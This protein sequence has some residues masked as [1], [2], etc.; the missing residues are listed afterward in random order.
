MNDLTVKTKTVVVASP[1]S[2]QARKITTQAETWGEL[3]EELGGMYNDNLEAVVRPGNQSLGRDDAKLPDEDFSV[4]LIPRKNK[5]GID[6]VFTSDDAT[7]LS[8][9]IYREAMNCI[10]DGSTLDELKENVEIHMD[11]FFDALAGRK[12]AQ[13]EQSKVQTD[14]VLTEALAEAKKMI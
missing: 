5:A 2:N 1:A 6:R 14:P 8:V 3:K 4:Y 7:N 12:V 10:A 11:S 9:E 13:A